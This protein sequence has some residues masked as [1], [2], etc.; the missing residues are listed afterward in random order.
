MFGFHDSDQRDSHSPNAAMLGGPLQSCPPTF[1]SW[2]RNTGCEFSEGRAPSAA[3][4][5]SKRLPGRC[6]IHSWWAASRI[7]AGENRGMTDR[8]KT[9]AVF[10]ADHRE[11]RARDRGT[12]E[13]RTQYQ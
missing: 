5:Y 1:Q 3:P 2:T 7:P 11:R 10:F 6:E 8:S 4:L 13:A 12:Q 9:V